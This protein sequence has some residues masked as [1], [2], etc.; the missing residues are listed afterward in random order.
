MATTLG[1][2]ILLGLIMSAFFSKLKLPG[3]LGML[4]VGVILGPYVLDT[5]DSDLLRVSGDFRKLALIIILLRAGLGVS[6]ESLHKVGKPALLMSFLPGLFEGFTIAFLAVWLL[7]WP[8]VVGGVL[9]FVLAAVSPAV[10]VPK[11]IQ[12]AQEG[13]GAQKGIPTLILASASVDDVFAITLFSAFVGMVS[14][15]HVNI[16]VQIAKIPVAILI[17]IALGII[18]GLVLLMIFK[19]FPMRDTRKALYL[20]AVAI[21]IT[22]VEALLKNRVEI[23]GLLGVMAIGFIIL[24]KESD[25][26]KRLAEK[27]GKIWILAELLLF[28]LVGAE[29]NVQVALDSGLL[30]LLIIAIGLLARSV[31][32]WL[33]TIGSGF[34]VR[35]RIFCMVA[36]MPKATVQAAIG[37]VP[38]ALGMPQGELIL[39]IAVLSIVVTAPLG[40]I[41]IHY[42]GEKWLSIEV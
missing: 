4:L 19:R 33:S 37:G 26:G 9:G 11:M 8:F 17:G 6:K 10:V 36:Y 21:I 23:A 24:E 5:M 31:G 22:A 1:I 39:A 35:E 30:G 27:Y 41:A 14:G 42:L 29:V 3:L 2:I 20:L 18:A 12:Y 16:G 25:L 32:V 34:T 13:R 15:S 38:L 40:A 7:D 28:V